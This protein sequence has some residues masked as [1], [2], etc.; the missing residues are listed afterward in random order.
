MLKNISTGLALTVVF[1][2]VAVVWLVFRLSKTM[3]VRGSIPR[4]QNLPHQLDC[5]ALISEEESKCD[6]KKC[7]SFIYDR[8]VNKYW[9]FNTHA[10]NCKANVEVCAN[11]PLRAFSGLRG[12]IGDRNWVNLGKGVNAYN[13]LKHK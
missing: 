4:S 9:A 2:F 1:I 11:C 12:Q 6:K 8:V 3:K 7:N 5:T 10:P 13:A